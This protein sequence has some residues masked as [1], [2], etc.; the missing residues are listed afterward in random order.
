[1]GEEY[2]ATTLVPADHPGSGR[3]SGIGYNTAHTGYQMRR[4]LYVQ[5]DA[6]RKVLLDQAQS[7]HD[8]R[9]LAA[10]V[11]AARAAGQSG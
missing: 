2:V 8:W 7:T 4:A 9:R 5:A 3:R 11:M 1:M 10:G 6:M